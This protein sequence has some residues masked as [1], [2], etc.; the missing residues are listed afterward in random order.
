[1]RVV[2]ASTNEQLGVLPIKE[3]LAKAREH[4]LDLVEVAA[5]ANPPVCRIIDYGKYR[6]EQAK[7][8]KEKK[9]HAGRVK[10]IKFRVNIDEH[11]YM[12]KIRH[13]EDFLD[14]GNKLKVVLMFRGRENAHPE[15]GFQVMDRVQ[16]DLA[17]MAQVEMQPRKSGRMI[18]MTLSPLPA[19]KRKKRFAPIDEPLE[20]ESEEPDESE[21]SDESSPTESVS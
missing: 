17:H 18:N 2:L 13:G 15:I 6:Y 14:K 8:E 9:Q 19:A 12:T 7:L 21:E 3:A 10:E 11:D 1:V 20:E 4:G 16:S 5:K